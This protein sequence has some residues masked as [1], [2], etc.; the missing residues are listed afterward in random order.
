MIMWFRRLLCRMFGH[1]YELHYER[2]SYYMPPSG[3][4]ICSRCGHK[5]E[6]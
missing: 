6:E 1:T 5:M 3:V 2:Q 4:L